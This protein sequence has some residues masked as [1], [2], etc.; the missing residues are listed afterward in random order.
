[1]ERMRDQKNIL[2]Q[3]LGPLQEEA[4]WVIG[5]LATMHGRVKRATIE[6][7]DKLT[8]LTAQGAEEIVTTEAAIIKAVEGA[9]T[10]SQNLISTWKS[11]KQA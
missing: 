10:T 4:V 6:V 8:N 5:E 2:Q 3:R 7:E 9:K 11:R 1:V